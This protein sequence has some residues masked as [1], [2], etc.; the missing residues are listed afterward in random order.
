MFNNTKYGILSIKM[1][2]YCLHCKV[3]KIGIY[4]RLK[5]LKYTRGDNVYQHE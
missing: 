3:L 2:N 5:Q 4:F 1:L